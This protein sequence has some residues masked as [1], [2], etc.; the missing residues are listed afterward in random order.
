VAKKWK[1][2][3]VL[4]VI[5]GRKTFVID[6]EGTVVH[7]YEGLLKAKHHVEEALDAIKIL[8]QEQNSINIYSH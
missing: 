6:K 5:A 3:S 1:V 8:Q 7:I 2:E 4:G